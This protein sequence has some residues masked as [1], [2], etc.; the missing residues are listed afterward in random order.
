M[1][2]RL[3]FGGYKMIDVVLNFPK[4]YFVTLAD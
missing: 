3:K 1:A 2:P 4:G